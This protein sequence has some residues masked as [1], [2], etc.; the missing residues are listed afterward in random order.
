MRDAEVAELRGAARVEED[1]RRLDVAMHDAAVVRGLEPADHVERHPPRPAPRA[2]RSPA[3]E[4]LRE[5]AA[6]Q[7]LHDEEAALDRDVVDLDERRVAQRAREPRLAHEPLVRRAAARAGGEEHLDRD[8]AAGDLVGREEHAA[9]RAGAEQL[10]EPV[11]PGDHLAIAAG[12]ALGGLRRASSRRYES[13]SAGTAGSAA[14]SSS[15]ASR[16]PS[17]RPIAASVAIRWRCASAR[18]AGVLRASWSR[19]VA[20]GYAPRRARIRPSA[21]WIGARSRVGREIE[22]ALEQPAGVAIAARRLEQARGVELLV[23]ARVQLDRARGVA[24]P[25]GERRG[26]GVAAQPDEHV[27]RGAR[28]VVGRGQRARA[29]RR[30]RRRRRARARSAARAAG[31]RRRAPPRA[32]RESPTASRRARRRARGCPPRERRAAPPR[33]GG[34]RRSAPRWTSARRNCLPPRRDGTRALS[35]TS[36][37]PIAPCSSSARSRSTTSTARSA[38][39]RDLLG[40]SA[41]FIARA[42][43]YFTKQRRRSSRV[44]GDDFPQKHVDELTAL[45]VDVSRHRAHAPARR[46][47]GSASTRPTSRPARRSTPGSAC[48]RRSSPSSRDAHTRRAARP[49][50]QHRSGAPARRAAP[51]PRARAGRRRHDEPVDQHQARRARARCSRR[52]TR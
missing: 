32:R 16:A 49:A 4:P 10:V 31:R 42:A 47:T 36:A 6:G 45:G 23:R 19:R 40:G 38:S 29:A 34:R 25:L 14:R 17:R 43:S 13:R 46:S 51:G 7:V 18:S 24:E 39:T 2:S 11:A 44:I 27:E 28:A 37:A 50:R 41:S 5:R 35:C 12:L 9:R 8:L 22:R 48:S 30:P 33:R 15:S 52:S 21:S 3:A 20:S 1:V 26:L